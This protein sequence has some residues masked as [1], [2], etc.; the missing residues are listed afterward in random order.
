[1]LKCTKC[2]QEMV[3]GTAVCPSCGTPVSGGTLKQLPQIG[4]GESIKLCFGKYATFSGRAR[5]SE[6]WYF[7]LFNFIIGLVLGM[8]PVLGWIL[9]IIYSLATILPSLAVAARRLHDSGKSGWLLLLL[10][11]PLIGGI[12]I[13]IFTLL[14]SEKGDN[15][16]G[17]STKYV[18]A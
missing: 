10:L 12:I 3:E 14:D 6:Y 5:R 13:F 15:Q 4:F 2:G 1:M 9:G 7:V 17:P 8:I 16:Y 18:V 11:I